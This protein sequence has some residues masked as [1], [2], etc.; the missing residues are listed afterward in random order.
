MDEVETRRLQ[1]RVCQLS[2]LETLWH[3]YN[4][5]DVLHYF[6]HRW[7]ET[8]D[9]MLPVLDCF[10]DH[11]QQHRY[12]MWMLYHKQQ[13][14]IIGQCGFFALERGFEAELIYLIAKEYRHQ[15]FAIEA[16]RASLRYAFDELGLERIVA[17]VQ[18]DNTAAQWVLKAIGMYPE[19]LACYDEHDLLCY[20]TSRA[21]FHHDDSFYL[22]HT[23]GE[24]VEGHYS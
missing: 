16:V 21:T 8:T 20:V 13:A 14:C 6:R 3:M 15:G 9:A 24:I 12:G 1:L 5:T 22:V 17:L 10:A 19:Y 7:I 18:A 2:D 11:W 23:G 4:D